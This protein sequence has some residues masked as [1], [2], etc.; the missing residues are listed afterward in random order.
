MAFFDTEI[1]NGL[2]IDERLR[3]K[4]QGEYMRGYS[5]ILGLRIANF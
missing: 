4:K 5:E 3:L 2:D 1:F